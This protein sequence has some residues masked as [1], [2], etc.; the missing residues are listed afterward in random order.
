MFSFFKKTKKEVSVKD[1][2]WLTS[3]YKLRHVI[4]RMGQDASLICIIW[5]RE[6]WEQ[7]EQL[8]PEQ[9][10][11]SRAFM[12]MHITKRDIVG[13]KIIFADHPP[14]LEKEMALFKDLG[15]KE[16]EVN[17]SLDEHFLE[18]IL[19]ENFYNLMKKLGMNEAEPIE[20]PLVS[21]SI[22]RAQEKYASA[23]PVL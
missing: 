16:V 2:V 9:E 11:I 8:N 12:H 20:H 7:F 1:K 17:T 19:H 6:T 21:A 15:L 23:H 5:Q 3:N 22:R 13:K 4:Q 10:I 18:G 14:S